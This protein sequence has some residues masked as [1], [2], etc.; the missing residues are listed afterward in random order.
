MATTTAIRLDTEA[1]PL[2]LDCVWDGTTYVVQVAYLPRD[3]GW[4]LSVSDTTGDMMVGGVP[5]IPSWPLLS[6]YKNTD[7]RL[8]RGDLFFVGQSLVYV[9][10][11]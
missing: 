2:V 7:S 3:D 9:E 6:R 8:P 1:P 4:Y 5:L 10:A 11:D